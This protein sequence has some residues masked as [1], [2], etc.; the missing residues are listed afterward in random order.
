[1][2]P[3]DPF[4]VAWAELVD[5][6][7]EVRDCHAHIDPPFN[8]SNVA[9]DAADL[10]RTMDLASIST[11]FIS[12]LFGIADEELGRRS[13]DLAATAF[14]DRLAPVP[15]ADPNRPDVA[16]AYLES[17]VG[18][19]R[20][21]MIK[22]HP[23]LHEYPV[24]G[25]GYRPIFEFAG[26]VGW[27]VL[28]HTWSG[29]PD[30]A[31]FATLARDHPATTF[32][33]GHSGGVL[34]GIRSAVDVARAHDNL[35]CDLACS[36]PYDGVL[37][38]MVDALGDERILFGTDATFFDPRPQLGR[39]V[40]SRIPPAAKVRILGANLERLIPFPGADVPGDEHPG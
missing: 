8:F 5:L 13:L 34:A 24:T 25:P 15:I 17:C 22:V 3:L 21:R 19:P 33:L 10:V 28:S 11:A 32:L 35:Y 16:I 30:P 29:G 1:M 18:D 40:L 26:S 38:W 6:G 20:V 12:A 4:D 2:T 37:E 31:A 27:P 23:T 9:P 39:V 14:P 36:I 7:V